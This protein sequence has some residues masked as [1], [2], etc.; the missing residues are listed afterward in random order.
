MARTVA[1]LIHRCNILSEGREWG[2]VG[3]FADFSTN[4]NLL[5]PLRALPG[6]LVFE[7]VLFAPGG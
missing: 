2:C 3:I 5:V 1:A 6:A 7:R 4:Q